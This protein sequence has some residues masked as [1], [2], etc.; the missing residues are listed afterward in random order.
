MIFFNFLD[1]QAGTLPEFVRHNE[2]LDKL[3]A[4]HF[5]LFRKGLKLQNF[6]YI[7]IGEVDVKELFLQNELMT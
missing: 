3:R 7:S 5:L 4:N 6:K 2:G 1:S